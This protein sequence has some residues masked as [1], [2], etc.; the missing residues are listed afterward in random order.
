MTV[1][2]KEI[3]LSYEAGWLVIYLFVPVLF[4]ASVSTENLFMTNWF[5]I[6]LFSHLW[7]C[8]EYSTDLPPTGRQ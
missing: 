6:L 1:L 7:N 5:I 8:Q 3:D 2:P 4:L